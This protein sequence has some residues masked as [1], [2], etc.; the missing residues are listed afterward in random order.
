MDRGAMLTLFQ[1]LAVRRVSNPAAVKFTPHMGLVCH[2]PSEQ[3]HL[4]GDFVGF[5]ADWIWGSR[6]YVITQIVE[7]A[8]QRIT[9]LQL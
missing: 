9:R 8:R 1:L 5:S 6:R 2:R 7:C 3:H 4:I